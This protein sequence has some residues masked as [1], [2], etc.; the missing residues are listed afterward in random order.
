MPGGIKVREEL[1]PSNA[2]EQWVPVNT[3]AVLERDRRTY[4]AIIEDTDGI[5]QPIDID[6]TSELDAIEPSTARQLDAPKARV[7]VSYA[8][9]DIRYHKEFQ[10]NLSILKNEGLIRVW[11]DGELRGGE[12]WDRTIRKEIEEC[13]VMVLLLSTAFFASKYILGVEMALARQLH[14]QGSLRVIPVKVEEVSLNS[15]TWLQ[16]LHIVPMRESRIVPVAG[17]R[18]HSHGWVLVESEL[19][20]VIEQLAK[21]GKSI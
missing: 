20:S 6:P 4:T 8:H 2:G 19:R 21:P 12:D 5:G 3:L 18:P 13:D 16:R 10:M 1:D 11:Y 7:F 9:R 15:H 17:F 14:S